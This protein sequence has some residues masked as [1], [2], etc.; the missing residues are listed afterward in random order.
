MTKKKEIKISG[1]K[2]RRLR[3]LPIPS[4]LSRPMLRCLKSEKKRILFQQV[5][6]EGQ[7]TRALVNTGATNNFI[8]KVLK[9]EIKMMP[10]K[11]DEQV[12]YIFTKNLSKPKSQKALRMICRSSVERSR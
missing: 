12:M 5:M 10:T 11:T 9:G 7:A 3:D 1:K 2:E 6:I 4:T 8:K